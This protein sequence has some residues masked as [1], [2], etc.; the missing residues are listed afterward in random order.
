MMFGEL[1]KARGV[2]C[3]A[4]Q[5]GLVCVLAALYDCRKPLSEQSIPKLEVA[6]SVLDSTTLDK[7][8]LVEQVARSLQRSCH[9][10]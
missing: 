8:L 4:G 6:Y 10:V 5:R 3:I 9:E 7:G 2:V 1:L